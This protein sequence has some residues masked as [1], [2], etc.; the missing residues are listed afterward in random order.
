MNQESRECQNCKENFV[1]EPEDF[2]F[3]EKIKVPP[4]TFCSR[5]RLQRRLA[6][7]N[8]W[9]LYK[10]KCDLCGQEK[11]SIFPPDAPYTV[12]CPECWWSDGWDPLRYGRDYDF[13]RTFFE[14]F[15]ELLHTAPLLGLSIDLD[16]VRVSPYNN[17]AGHLKN[18]YLLFFGDF[19]EDCSYG[20]YHVQNKMLFDCSLAM[21]SELSYDCMNIFK[22]SRCV[23]TRGNITESLNCAFLRDSDNCQ[24]CFA[25]ANLKNKKH[26]IF[27]KPYAREDYQREIKKWDLGSYKTY[28]E[29]ERLA[30]EHW[31]KFPPRPKYDDFSINSTGSYVFQSKNCKECFDVTGVEDSKFLHMLYIPPIK[32][33]Y[34]VT[35]WGNNIQLMYECCVVGENASNIRFCQESGLNL[36]NAEYCKLGTGGSNLFGCVSAKKGN[37]CILNKRYGEAEFQELRDRIVRHIDSMPYTDKQGRA[38]RYGEFFP[39]ELSPHAYNETLAHNFFPLSET[40]SR[41]KGFRWRDTEIHDYK[42][43]KPSSALPDHIKDADDSI[44]NETIGCATCPRGFKIIR[45][46]LDFLRKMN[47][48]LPRRCPFCRT[49]DKFK[50]WVKQLTLTTRTCAKCGATFD[51]N[52]TPED[53]PEI[54]CKQCYLQEVI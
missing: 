42:I 40:E 43:T 14:Q 8:L 16:T 35:S 15:N 50:Q 3:Y 24:D 7:F 6:F 12:Y 5:C 51:T 41:Q 11:I 28:Q 38:Y 25:S 44:L 32:D 23:G 48:P 34:D 1:V 33:C 39:P 47:L 22:S 36:Y 2:R 37:Y 45:S 18:C 19:N 17:H 21:F 53:A 4:P 31:K 46:E 26:H 29:A 10:R 52:Y 9:Q 30:H 49:G 13:K 20:F 54:L 27:N